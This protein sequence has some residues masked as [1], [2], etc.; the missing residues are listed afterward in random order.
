M[1]YVHRDLLVAVFLGVAALGQARGQTAAESLEK[2][3]PD[4]RA[5][6]L[7]SCPRGL[8]PAL[9]SDC[10]VRQIDAIQEPGWPDLNILS[11]PAKAW[12]EESCPSSL[13]PSLWRDCIERAL[14]ALTAVDWPNVT[15]LEPAD[16]KWVMET[17]PRSLGPSLWRDCAARQIEALAPSA[18]TTPPVE[19]NP[20]IIAAP[21]GETVIAEP[22]GESSDPGVGRYPSY[23][24]APVAM[25]GHS[26]GADLDA[27]EVYRL[28]APSVYMV[29]AAPSV[30][31][32]RDGDSVSQG[33]A[34]AI[35]ERLALTNCH[36]I[37]S[38]HSIFLLDGNRP[39]AATVWAADDD[40]DRC[41][42]E[43]Q[44]SLRPIGG[45]RPSGSVEI[46]EIAYTIG[47]P[48][49]LKSSFGQGLVSG[50]RSDKGLNI[51]QT[52]APISGGSSGGA[53]VDGRG[54]LIGITTFLLR[55]SENLN[56]AIAAEEFFGGPID[57]SSYGTPLTAAEVS[58]P[59]MIYNNTGRDEV[60]PLGITTTA[61]MN[62][63]IKLVEQE[64]GRDQIGV[65]IRGGEY[66]RVLVPLGNYVIRYATGSE[67][68]GTANLFGPKTNYFEAGSVFTFTE[69][70]D[71][72]SGY[73][74]KLIPQAGGNLQTS[75][76]SHDQ[77]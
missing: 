11:A 54:N 47:N 51:I 36:V 31:A 28:V 64:T 27:R 32:L 74:I 59:G 6:V 24:T 30:E 62:Y 29:V 9:W 66:L 37:G 17:C 69:T 44:A 3:P 7:E 8:G 71:G 52:T 21:L 18:A 76:I 38:N 16:Q 41:I 48:A 42:L 25:P 5:W 70:P 45:A 2:L 53:L 63:F 75:R 55:D 68:L 1:A 77:F 15:L 40:G 35:S 20:P 19:Q 26:S 58:S 13:G 43:S 14:S 56:F 49:G 4:W 61:G 10:V 39:L 23:R 72:Y 50:I 67:W 60:A 12:A 33:S 73:G 57:L 46:G 34:V 22:L 65:L